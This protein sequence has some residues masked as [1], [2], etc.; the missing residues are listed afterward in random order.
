M[1]SCVDLYGELA[2]RWGRV[3]TPRQMISHRLTHDVS[4]GLVNAFP[5]FPCREVAPA[6]R[7]RS[8]F[9]ASLPVSAH[10]RLRGV[11]SLQGSRR[12]CVYKTFPSFLQVPHQPSSSCFNPHPPTTTKTSKHTLQI[13]KVTHTQF[14]TH[15]DPHPSCRV[16]CTKSKMPLPA[17][18]THPRL[19]L[20]TKATMVRLCLI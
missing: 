10:L 4:E 19:L 9:V 12:S 2:G 5:S 20:L 3:A 16:L 8:G 6:K 11:N 7:A 18:R 15:L 14:K 13:P 1:I 17:R